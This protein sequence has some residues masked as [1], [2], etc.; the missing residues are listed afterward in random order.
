MKFAAPGYRSWPDRLVLMPPG[1][2]YFVEL[3]A[4]GKKPTAQQ[5]LRHTQLGDLGF[6]VSVLDSKTQVESFIKK[7]S[8]DNP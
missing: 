4:P 1:H 7:I 2:V 6:D 8:S 5:V 3:K